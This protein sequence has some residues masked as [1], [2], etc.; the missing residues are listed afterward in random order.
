[1]YIGTVSVVV[2]TAW[3]APVSPRERVN[4]MIEPARIA[5]RIAGNRT[6]RKTCTGF[7]PRGRAGSSV[8]GASGWG[9]PHDRPL[10]APEQA[11][12]DPE[13]RARDDVRDV[14][15]GVKG[16]AQ[17]AEPA[18]GDED[19]E[20]HARRQIDRRR[21]PSDE[22]G[23]ADRVPEAAPV[24]VRR[25]GDRQEGKEEE[26]RDE[27]EDDEE[28]HR[29]HVPEPGIRRG[30]APPL[31]PAAGPPRSALRRAPAA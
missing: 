12:G 3:V 29:A 6:R 30:G 23:H 26:G 24:H 22:E 13:G 18:A 21:D 14:H 19:R 28:G 9:A 25:R 31:Q 16:L 7:A 2:D 27:D 15:E 10:G 17:T 1:M 5:G 4:A 20:G 8:A 11:Q